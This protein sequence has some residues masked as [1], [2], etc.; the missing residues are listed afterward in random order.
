M[1]NHGNAFEDFEVIRAR[2]VRVIRDLE[3]AC[4]ELNADTK[5]GQLEQLSQQLEDETFRVLVVGEFK[6]GKSTLINAMLSADLLPAGSTPCTA[7]VTHIRYG[8]RR[9]AVLHWRDGRPTTEI[10]LEIPGASLAPYIKI[11]DFSS[12][13]DED[14]GIRATPYSFVEVYWP[15]ELCRLGIEVID[16]PGLNEHYLRTHETMS[17]LEVADAVVCLLICTKPLSGT[18]QGF[19]DTDLRDRNLRDAFFLWNH[20]DQVRHKAADVAEL[21]RLSRDRLESRGADPDRI[22]WVSG[23]EALIGRLTGHETAV[24]QSGIVKFEQSLKHFLADER[25]RAKLTRPLN[26][27]TE[28]IRGDLADLLIQQERL[29]R[30]PLKEFQERVLQCHPKLHSAQQIRREILSTVDRRAAMM[31]KEVRQALQ[32]EMQRL[33]A[34]L[35]RR[36]ELDP[37][38]TWEAFVSQSGLMKRLGGALARWLSDEMVSWQERELLGLLTR[39][40]QE[41]QAD[42]DLSVKRFIGELGDVRAIMGTDL[43]ETGIALPADITPLQ[44]LLGG[45]LGLLGGPRSVTE[46][47]TFDPL[48]IARGLALHIGTSVGL[49]V[50]SFGGFVIL[51]VL[52]ALCGGLTVFGAKKVVAKARGKVVAEIQASMTAGSLRLEREIIARLDDRIALFR[53]LLENQLAAFVEDFQKQLD[54]ILEVRLSKRRESEVQLTRLTEIRQTVL[55]Q[56]AVLDEI[57]EK[58]EPRSNSLDVAHDARKGLREELAET[59][60]AA[61]FA[62]QSAPQTHPAK[63]KVD[64]DLKRKLEELLKVAGPDGKTFVELHDETQSITGYGSPDALRK[65]AGVLGWTGDLIVVVGEGSSRRVVLKEFAP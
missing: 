3:G 33:Y 6:N 24:S 8:D 4:R 12:A 11:Q 50:A 40:F 60:E 49:L 14:P 20:F 45:S 29:Y 47:T 30:L 36:A 52:A 41:L 65:R 57:W 19:I 51:P 54:A 23:E 28:A 42:L 9:R 59:L 16:S 44:G 22:F 7:V 39:H 5:A 55:S 26:V 64:A 27:A 56:A 63:A 10:D 61:C 13:I 58:L 46:D 43:T 35:P 38:A 53:G 21:C 48:L 62:L 31:R 32:V 17:V 1:E 2:L 37:A 18:E 15:L 34:D 25:G